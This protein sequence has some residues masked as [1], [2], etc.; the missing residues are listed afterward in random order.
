MPPFSE[1]IKKA[2]KMAPRSWSLI[3]RIDKATQTMPFEWLQ[4]G[5]KEQNDGW[6][7]NE[8]KRPKREDA[9]TVNFPNYEV[10]TEHLETG[11]EPIGES[12]EEVQRRMLEVYEDEMYEPYE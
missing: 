2:A 9:A 6:G 4:R 8:R 1:E 11:E 10:E 5:W 7:E 12:L 3:G